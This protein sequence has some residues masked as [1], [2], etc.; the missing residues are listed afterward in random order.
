MIIGKS[1][2]NIA[3]KA[4]VLA[5][6]GLIFFAPNV[7][8]GQSSTQS[9]SSAC[10]RHY[11]GEAPRLVRPNMATRAREL[12]NDEF[13][14]L[15]SAQT[16]TPLYASEHLVRDKI[17][18]AR[19]LEREEFFHED[20]RLRDEDRG[21]LNDYRRSGFDRGHVAASG[22]MATP[23]GRYQ[24]FSLANILPQN[25]DN[26]QRL[27]CSIEST[28][29][30][31]AVKQGEAWVVTGP[32]FIGSR[33]QALNNRV[34]VPTHLFKAVVTSGGVSG[35]YVTAN[36]DGG[37]WQAISF[38]DLA[39]ISGI[40]PFPKLSAEAKSAPPRLPAPNKLCRGAAPQRGVVF[41]DRDLP[42]PVASQEA[43]SGQPNA[44]TLA[45]TGA[46]GSLIQ[47]MP[48]MANWARESARLWQ[49]L[50]TGR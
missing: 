25:P 36:R 16:R 41:N 45:P 40:D 46:T 32:I 3:R 19:E 27:W 20:E 18:A 6:V 7:S 1:P 30:D 23:Q 50:Q 4:S 37:T 31:L 48:E 11:L 29:R 43:P 10:A 21:K 33:V 17:L 13:A 8:E 34:W 5:I 22:N 42:R 2:R 47:K 9:A 44:A 26:N 39:D 14:V 49:H 12:C 38:S 15:H 35:V 24:S 28:V